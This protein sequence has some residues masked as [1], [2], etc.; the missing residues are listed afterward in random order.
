M[1]FYLPSHQP[2]P[3]SSLNSPALS[4]PENSY[5]T[6]KTQLKLFPTLILPDTNVSFFNHPN[7]FD[8]LVIKVTCC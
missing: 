1:S 6:Y 5:S 8:T 7:S 3:L 4:L 2:S